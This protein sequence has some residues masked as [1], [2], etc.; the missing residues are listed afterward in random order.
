MDKTINK[1]VIRYAKKIY[2]EKRETMKPLPKLLDGNEVMK[3]LSITPSHRLGEIMSALKEAQISG[4]VNTKE[5]AVTFV[6][7][8]RI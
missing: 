1:R 7:N 4:E 8:N 2:F 6:K 5:E 3:I